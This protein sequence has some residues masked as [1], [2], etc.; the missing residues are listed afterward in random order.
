[1]GITQTITITATPDEVYDALMSSEKFAALTGAPAEIDA[2]DGGEFSCFGGQ[3]TGR[4]IE[5]IAGKQILQTWRAGPWP[6]DVNSTVRIELQA[7]RDDTT[8][9]LTQSDFPDEMTEHL[10]D[11]WHKMYWQPLKA[12]LEK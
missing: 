3:I 5:N 4:Q 10:E 12:Y 6:D 9:T 8:I 2:E 1:M 11:G 7:N